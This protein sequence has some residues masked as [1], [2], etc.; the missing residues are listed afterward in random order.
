MG[1]AEKCDKCKGTGIVRGDQLD[2]YEKPEDLL[3]DDTEYTCDWCNGG[4]FLVT[5]Y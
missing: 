2:D 4:G 3:Y 5:N 1:I